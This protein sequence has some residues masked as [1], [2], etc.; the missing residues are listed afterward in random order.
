MFTQDSKTAKRAKSFYF[1]FLIINYM[2]ITNLIKNN[3]QTDRYFNYIY[4]IKLIMR[5]S[6]ASPI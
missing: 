4:D 6:E 1:Y 2:K 3:I 5:N